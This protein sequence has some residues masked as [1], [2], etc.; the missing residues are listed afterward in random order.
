MA[1]G[2]N[3][4]EQCKRI[5]AELRSMIIYYLRWGAAEQPVRSLRPASWRQSSGSSTAIW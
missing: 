3:A 4:L 2:A 5:V 1:A